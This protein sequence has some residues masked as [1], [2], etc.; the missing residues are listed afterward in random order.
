MG[1]IPHNDDD[2]DEEWPPEGGCLGIG[3]VTLD[4][5][6]PTQAEK[7]A[8]KRRQPIGFIHFPDRD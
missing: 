8:I 6:T 2:D 3:F 5:Y 1:A 4:Q 7:R